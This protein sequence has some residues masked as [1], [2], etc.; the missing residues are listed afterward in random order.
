MTLYNVCN[1]HLKTLT[2]AR[3][4]EG[5][6]IRNEP[7]ILYSSAAEHHRTLASAHFPSRVG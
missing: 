6:H 1:S 4:N 2:L 3:I 7:S 5:S